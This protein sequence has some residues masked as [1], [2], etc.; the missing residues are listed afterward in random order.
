MPSLLYLKVWR[1]FMEERTIPLRELLPVIRDVLSSGGEFHLKPRGE[2]MLPY[3]REG[4]DS[5]VLSSLDEPPKRGDILLYVR[6]NGVPVLHRVVRIEKN[7]SLTMRGDSQYFLER[8]I[9]NEQVVAV[10]KKFY[11]RDKEK[12]TDSFSSRLY[13]ARRHI[14]YPFRRFF[15]AVFHR[16]KRILRRVIKHG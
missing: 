15:R 2:S 11:R 7:G 9:C 14:T 12:S 5:V 13:C 3:L 8:G 10:V 4:R 6:E 16:T 1:I